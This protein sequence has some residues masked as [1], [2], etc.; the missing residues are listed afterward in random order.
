LDYKVHSLQTGTSNTIRKEV[1]I[2]TVSTKLRTVLDTVC[3]IDWEAV[4]PIQPNFWFHILLPTVPATHPP[5]KRTFLLH[6]TMH[7]AASNKTATCQKMHHNGW[8][9][10][11]LQPYS[12][13]R[14]NSTHRCHTADTYMAVGCG[15]MQLCEKWL[16]KS[17][18]KTSYKRSQHINYRLT[19]TSYDLHVTATFQSKVL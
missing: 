11:S 6:F 17:E 19:M 4:L 15:K 18:P 7:N 3:L 12:Q 14:S 2:S 8:M 1:I 13:F 5:E 9:T 10:I 16:H